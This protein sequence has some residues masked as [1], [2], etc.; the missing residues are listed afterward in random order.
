MY[1]MW[2]SH[3]VHSIV[4]KS[5]ERPG[6]WPSVFII[7]L[8]NDLSVFRLVEILA[9]A[10][11][12]HSWWFLLVFHFPWDLWNR[13]F[14]TARSTPPKNATFFGWFCVSP[15]GQ[16]FFSLHTNLRT[17]LAVMFQTSAFLWNVLPLPSLDICHDHYK[18]SPKYKRHM[19]RNM[20]C[21]HRS[22]K[23]V[24]NVTWS[25]FTEVQKTCATQHEVSSPKYKGH[26]QPNMKCVHRSTKDVC[27]VTWSV[28]T[29]VQKRC[30]T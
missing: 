9:F 26:L 28:F 24:C 1:W 6:N 16:H 12:L 22:T 8:K 5:S 11:C 29:E 14:K 21:V 23:D 2:R 18:S 17:V 27:N 19:Q 7:F 13:E 3:A 15:Q 4:T 10:T 20:K 25:V 30:A